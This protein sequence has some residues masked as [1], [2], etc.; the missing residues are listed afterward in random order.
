VLCAEPKE[1]HYFDWKF[2]RGEHWYLTHYPWKSRVRDVR[3][4]ISAEPAVGEATPDYLFYSWVPRR[5]HAFD[6]GLRFVVLLRDPVDRAYSQYQMQV[7]RR[8]E[9]RS[10]DEVLALEAAEWPSERERILRDPD[11]VGTIP[12]HHSYVARGLYAEQLERWFTLFDP[13]RFLV[14]TSV[15][16]L[17]DTQTTMNRI[18]AFLGVP[19]H[20]AENYERLSAGTYEPMAAETREHLARTFEP[21]NRRLEELLGRTFEWTRPSASHPVLR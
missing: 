13:D 20:V 5:V 16:L 14:L 3:T 17:H 8:G 9:A 15:E 11:H 7:R 6:P 1:V 12:L 10:F 18:T 2:D 21:H 19:E 4:R